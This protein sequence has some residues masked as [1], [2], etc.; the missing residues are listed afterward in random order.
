MTDRE[1][2][3]ATTLPAFTIAAERGQ[4]AFF[5]AVVGDTDP[6]HIDVEAAVAAGHPDV[7]VPPTF[8]F[9]LELRRPEPYR[10]LEV[11]GADL[12]E[13]LHGEQSFVYHKSVHAGD[14]LD[15]EPKI[16][17]YFE[18][19]DGAMRFIVRRTAVRRRGGLVA[20]LENTLILRSG[21]AA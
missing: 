12:S 8:L 21:R 3:L 10:M 18:K 1:A 14:V 11:I 20:E 15:F 17:D 7:V 13:A 5:A 16:V 4:L 9:S 6:L 19:K 2:V